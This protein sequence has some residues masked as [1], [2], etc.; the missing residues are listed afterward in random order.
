[1]IIKRKLLEGKWYEFEEGIEFLIRPFKFSEYRLKNKDDVMKSLKAKFI[2]CLVDWKGINDE[3][4]KTV[5]K[6][7]NEN[8]GLLFDHYNEVREF[9]S[10][11]IGK[12]EE[13]FNKSLKN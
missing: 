9:I 7:T 8:K 13:D 3:D 5:F 11:K 6:C 4:D 12:I 1:M 2:F 10:E